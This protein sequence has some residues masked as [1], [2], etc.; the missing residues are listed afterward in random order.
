MDSLSNSRLYSSNV[1]SLVMTTTR[2]AHSLLIA[3][4]THS[5]LIARLA[6]S[7]LIARLT[8]SNS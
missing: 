4:L 8:H 3:R 2:L 5:L 7:L 6:C 1:I